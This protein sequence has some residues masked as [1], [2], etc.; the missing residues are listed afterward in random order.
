MSPV[1]MIEGSRTMD[2]TSERRVAERRFSALAAAVRE[3]EA[4][5]RRREYSSARRTSTCTGAYARSS[6][7]SSALPTMS[8]HVEGDNAEYGEAGLAAVTVRREHQ[9]LGERRAR[10]GGGVRPD[11]NGLGHAS[12]NRV[13]AGRRTQDD[14]V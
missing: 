8:G 13:V 9:G 7:T 14:L 10:S 3:H 1:T 11:R 6:A 4:N 12:R 5:V 2:A